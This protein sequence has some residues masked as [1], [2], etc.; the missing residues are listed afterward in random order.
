[1]AG[2]TPGQ[3]GGNG[4]PSPLADRLGSII[5]GRMAGLAQVP[6]LGFVR[7]VQRCFHTAVSRFMKA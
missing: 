5:E 2:H 4:A 7:A 3:E 6:Y 1:M